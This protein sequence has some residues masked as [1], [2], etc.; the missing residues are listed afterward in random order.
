MDKNIKRFLGIDIGGTTAKYSIILSD[1]QIYKQDSFRTGINQ[2]KEDFLEALYKVIDGALLE[3]IGGIGICSLGFVNSETGIIISGVENMPFLEGIN[4]KEII[5]RKYGDI[6]VHI[7]NDAK[8][9]AR[10]ENWLGAGKDC[11]SF[12]LMT[13]GTGLGGALVIDSKVVEGANFRAG[14]IGYLDYNNSQ[15]FSERYISTK[16]VMESAARKLKVDSITGIEFFEKIRNGD[17]VCL[18]IL[19]KWIKGISRVVANIIILIDP[20]KII[21]GGGVSAEKDILIPNLINQVKKMLPFEYS[22]QIAIDA[23]KC[24]NNAGM[25]GAV[26]PFILQP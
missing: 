19:D 5:F 22:D 15:D 7:S 10:G 9:A 4:F 23:A 11:S 17:E 1:G 21:I 26:S 3:D 16:F 18:D 20:D 13:L 12:F 14:E 6:P 24:N 25:L 8:A 2:R